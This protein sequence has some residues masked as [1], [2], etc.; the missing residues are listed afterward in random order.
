MK[1]HNLLLEKEEWN[2]NDVLDECQGAPYCGLE[3]C[4]ML[5]NIEYI[6]ISCFIIDI[7]HLCR[8]REDDRRNSVGIKG[9]RGTSQPNRHMRLENKAQDGLIDD[10]GFR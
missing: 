9:Y 3:Y 1:L 2:Y 10:N 5:N 6:G 4:W 7:C 8:F